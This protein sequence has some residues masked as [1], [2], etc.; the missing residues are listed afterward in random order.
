MPTILMKMELC[1]G[2]E[3]KVKQ[4][5]MKTLTLLIK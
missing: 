3:Q 2:W 5:I 1:I 4:N